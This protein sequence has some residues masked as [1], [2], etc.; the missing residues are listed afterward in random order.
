[1]REYA[2]IFAVLIVFGAA[3]VTAVE[4]ATAACRVEAVSD[5]QADRLVKHLPPDCTPAEREAHAVSAAALM[6]AI[7]KGRAVDLVGV[8]V[9]GDLSFDGL[10]VQTTQTPKGLSA[11]QQAA[12]AQLNA[13][14]LRRVAAP[15]T[16][17]DSL[18]TGAVRHR[19]AKG[20]LQF[21][22]PID[23]HG[24]RF[25]EG[26]DLSRAV[27]Q[28]AVDLSGAV[29][30]KEAYFV[31]SQF[32]HVFRCTDTKFGP[33]TRFHR[34]V[35][36]GVFE[37]AG[38]IFDG[39]AELL[40]VRFEQPVIMERARFGSGTGFS[41]SRFARHAN[42]SE[43]IF[44]RDA[45]FAFTVFEGDATFAG[46]QF[47]GGGDFSDAEFKRPDDLMK[48]RFDHPP[49]LSRTKQLTDDRKTG[50]LDSPT[51]QYAVTLFFLLMA[52]LLVAYAFKIK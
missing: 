28:G 41:G 15:V 8:V 49:V 37:C 35:F 22:G 42:F 34:S 43:S 44:S 12:L 52:A 51:G 11:E 19:S 9:Q 32:S 13:E 29:F 47:L 38:A 50:L 20:S 4:Q 46:A 40:E 6:A 23:L 14:E 45:F 24:T 1:M 30:E 36:R 18:V 2:R 33:H 5:A 25:R 10:P 17:R 39:M 21:E 31:Q 26:V 16:I 27:F 3:M 7:K 48:A